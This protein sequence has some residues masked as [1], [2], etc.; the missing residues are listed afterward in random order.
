MGVQG[1]RS[2]S[3]LALDEVGKYDWFRGMIARR[4]SMLWWMGRCGGR[5]MKEN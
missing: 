3:G 1:W 5:Y 4:V 2:V